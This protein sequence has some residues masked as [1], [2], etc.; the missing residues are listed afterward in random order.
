MVHGTA[1]ATLAGMVKYS[2]DFRSA[3]AGVLRRGAQP[4]LQAGSQAAPPDA[5]GRQ[6]QDPRARSRPRHRTVRAPCPC[7]RVDRGG[8]HDVQRDR[9][10]AGRRR[11]IVDQRRATPAEAASARDRT[12]V[13]RERKPHPEAIGIWS[14]LAAGRL[15]ARLDGTAAQCTP[16]RRRRLYPD[17]RGATGWRARG[18][19][20]RTSPRGDVFAEVS[21]RYR[22]AERRCRPIPS[23]SRTRAG[24][25]AGCDGPR[26]PAPKSRAMP[27]AS[28]SIRHIR[29]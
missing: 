7:C 20:V 26:Q 17:F 19:A 14:A 10:T 18:S 27:R 28:S 5:V 16:C 8:T 9:A 12:S 23:F 11:A 29:C 1:L 13:F 3:S 25:T 4:Q 21:V 6:P 24:R 22:P 2:A 15:A